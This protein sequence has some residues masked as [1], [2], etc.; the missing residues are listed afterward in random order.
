MQ[1]DSDKL[2]LAIFLSIALHALALAL[3]VTGNYPARL[4]DRPNAPQ[5]K[6]EVLLLE[7]LPPPPEEIVAKTLQSVAT[8]EPALSVAPDIQ[9]APSRTAPTLASES[10]PISMMAP[11]TPTAEEWAFA[12]RYTLKNSKGYRYTWGQQVRSMM[13]TAFEGPDQGVVRFRVE[14]SPDGTMAKL[15]TLWTTSP[16]AEQLAREAIESMPPLPPTPTG[17]PLIFE[18]TISFSPFV[19]DTPPIYRNDCLRDP[20]T[21]RNP[22]EGGGLGPPVRAEATENE[23]PESFSLEECL[24]QLPQDSIEAEAAHDLQE[25]RRWGPALGR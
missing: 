9:V 25:L 1:R 20:P 16:T 21:F 17:K 4:V 22:F 14:I 11:A 5:P 12:A 18:R 23:D 7:L 13:G 15:E 10:Q 8:P 6:D 24:K 2:F 19:S 3:A